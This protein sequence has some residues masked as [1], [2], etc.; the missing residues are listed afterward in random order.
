M[1]AASGYD[2]F[3][4]YSHKHDAVHKMRALRIFLDTAD[5]AANPALWASIEEARDGRSGSFCS[6]SRMP[7]SPN[8]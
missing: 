7:L 4:S 8:G 6:L 5:L 3:I 1:T 2:A